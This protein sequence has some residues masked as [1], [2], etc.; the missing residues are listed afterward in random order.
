MFR[1]IDENP[2]LLCRPV[3]ASVSDVTAGP[4]EVHAPLVVA[5]VE[6]VLSRDADGETAGLLSQV[7]DHVVTVLGATADGV[8]FCGH[9]DTSV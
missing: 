9:E 4:D 2:H 8:R 7:V 1:I 6:R 3:A 5:R